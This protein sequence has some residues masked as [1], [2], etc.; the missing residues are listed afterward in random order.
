MCSY[1]NVTSKEETTM[2]LFRIKL[3][4]KEGLLAKWKF[5]FLELASCWIS[6]VTNVG[7]LVCRLKLKEFFKWPGSTHVC[8]ILARYW[9]LGNVDSNNEKLAKWS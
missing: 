7:L 5:Q 6:Y 9:K 8:I 3:S 1:M 4:L 2:G